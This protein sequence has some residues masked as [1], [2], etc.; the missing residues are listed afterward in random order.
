M[1][2]VGVG[3]GVPARPGVAVAGR[4]DGRTRMMFPWSSVLRS[5]PGAFRSRR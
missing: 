5:G 1:I 3:T 2:G 4:G